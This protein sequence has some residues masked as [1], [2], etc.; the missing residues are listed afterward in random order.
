MEY[1]S[2]ILPVSKKIESVLEPTVETSSA[3]TASL[4]PTSAALVV[5]TSLDSPKLVVRPT[6]EG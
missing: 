1:A 5:A 6:P 4:V 2:S 3:P